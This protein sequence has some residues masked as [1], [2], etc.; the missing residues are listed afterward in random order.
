[1]D[2]RQRS[3]EKQANRNRS[4]EQD[5]NSGIMTLLRNQPQLVADQDIYSTASRMERTIFVVDLSKLEAETDTLV[6]ALVFYHP[7]IELKKVS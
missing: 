5:S 3:R 2:Q 4:A 1:M 7:E 6:G